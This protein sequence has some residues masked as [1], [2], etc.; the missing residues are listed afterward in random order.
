M[1]QCLVMSKS[2][3]CIKP[4]SDKWLKIRVGSLEMSIKT[5]AHIN[6]VQV[7]IS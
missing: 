6:K 7:N 3:E 5:T 2:P 4:D 1:T